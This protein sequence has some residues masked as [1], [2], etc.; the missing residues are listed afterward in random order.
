MFLGLGLSQFNATLHSQR[1]RQYFNPV[2]AGRFVADTAIMGPAGQWGAGSFTAPFAE[3]LGL[4][5][6]IA[7]SGSFPANTTLDGDAAEFVSD[8]AWN[9]AAGSFKSDLL[10]FQGI[11]GTWPGTGSILGK[12]GEIYDLLVGFA[13]AFKSDID[14]IVGDLADFCSSLDATMGGLGL[15]LDTS[16]ATAAPTALFATND[17]AIAGLPGYFPDSTPPP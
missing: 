16:A 14:P 1:G 10:P 13:G 3:L 6:T 12:A 7:H 2:H 4:T 15:L 5:Q 11:A 8:S 9:G 17:L